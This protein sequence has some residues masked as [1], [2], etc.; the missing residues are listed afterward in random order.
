LI[1]SA[2]S[3]KFQN[4]HIEAMKEVAL[5]SKNQNLLQFSKCA[6][7]Y[8]RELMDDFVIRRHFNLL[9]NHLLE[10][11]LKKIILPYSEV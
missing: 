5:A 10:D 1:N 6:T 3:L 11:N 7:T 9:Y 2:I 8:E 4:R